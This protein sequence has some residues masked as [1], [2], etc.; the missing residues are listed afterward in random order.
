MLGV[1]ELFPCSSKSFY[2]Y[3]FQSLILIKAQASPRKMKT[4]AQNGCYSV[5]EWPS[6]SLTFIELTFSQL[7]LRS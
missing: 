7:R 5:D 4:L 6:R 3:N 1:R 2:F